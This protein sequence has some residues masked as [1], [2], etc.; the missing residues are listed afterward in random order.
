MDRIDSIILTMVSKW[1]GGFSNHP[2]DRGG[3]TNH[4]ITATVYSAFIG[5]QASEDEV[6]KMP[7]Q[8]ALA[9]YRSRYWRPINID[10]LPELLQPIVFDTAVNMGPNTAIRLLQQGL[11]DLG[12][13]LKV[14]G[15]AGA[16]TSKIAHSAVAKFGAKPVI[17]ALLDLRRQRYL[18]IVAND[19]SQDAF[20]NGWLNRCESYRLPA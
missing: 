11:S 19:P 8:I 9:I 5:H 18:K 10:F 13:I 4:G 15:I 1:E 3:P 14:D 2:A 6:R 20:L 17:D 16:T 12:Y 7:L